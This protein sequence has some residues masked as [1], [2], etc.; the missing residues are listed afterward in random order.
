MKIYKKEFV[1]NHVSVIYA[2]KLQK[3]NIIIIMN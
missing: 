1:E 2:E 3:K